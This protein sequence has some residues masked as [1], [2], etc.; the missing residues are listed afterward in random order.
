MS[1]LAR[2]LIGLVLASAIAAA[3]L[4]ARMLTRS[5]AWAA[6]M[7]GTV[8][9]AA[10][11]EWCA[12][13]LAFFLSSSLLSRW[14]MG[15]KERLTYSV[16][17]KSGARDAWQVL[18]NGGV[19]AVAA[20]GMIVQPSQVWTL[21][22]LGA[23]AGATADTWATEIG[24]AIG[25]TPRSLLGWQPVPAGTSGAI[26]LAGTAAMC[27]GALFLGTVAALSGFAQGSV[28]PV[29][30]G[31]IG[32]ALVDTWVGATMQERRWC[33]R[34]ALQTER[35]VH[36][37]GA[38]TEWRGGLARLDNDVVNLTSCIAGAVIALAL[39]RLR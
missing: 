36:H 5:G 33:A 15:T 2:T 21:V 34:C 37:C 23:L 1:I 35:L 17:A 4:R 10:G 18:A 20:L 30:L 22:G 31:G 16:V 14:R 19:F 8:A 7:V 9:C 27:A 24:T 3:A 12:T 6:A 13:L 39:G 11:W 29:V 28:A 38:A 26:T 25:G 32:G